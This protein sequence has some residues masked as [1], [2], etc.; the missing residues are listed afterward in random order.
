MTLARRSFLT[1]ATA[2]LLLP[3]ARALGEDFAAIRERARGQRVYFNHWGGS[4]QINDYIAWAGDEVKRRF[5]VELVSVKLSDTAEA[6]GRVL[7]EKAAGRT[8]G[9]SV[10]LVWINGENFA[11]MKKNGLLFGPFVDRLPNFA[12][13]DTVGK[14]TTLVD[15]TIPTDGLEAPWGMAQFV[16]FFDLA[17]LAQPP[18]SITALLAWA[19]R[20]PGRFTYPAPPD[21]IGSTFLKHVLHATIDDPQRLQG[22]AD[23]ATF[24]GQTAGVWAWCDAIRP[25]LWRA[26]TTYP[27]NK[28]ALHQL[29]D[30][31]EVELSMAFNPSEASSLIAN[32][33][34]P[35]TVRTF[36]FEEGTIANTHFLAIPFNANAKEGA[37]VVIDFLLSPE[38]QARKADERIWGDPTVLDLDRLAPADRAL[39]DASPRGP[40]TLPPEALRPALP[41][42]HPSWM[43]LLEQ[44]WLARYARG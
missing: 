38:A 29:L 14:P 27:A 21:F 25:H 17:R 31:G 5:G 43:E 11:A 32:G 44:A 16:L 13:V 33:R 1:L 30:D 26:G 4:A 15:F 23:P 8:S 2:P 6:V 34:L 28:E 9:G 20:N 10:D 40:A 42:P 12:L 36:L 22:P 39:F 35:A 37:M 7:A 3:A 24:A 41:E 19:T 18:R